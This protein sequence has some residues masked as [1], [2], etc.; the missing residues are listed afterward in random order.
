MVLVA[1]RK[2]VIAEQSVESV[3][4]VIAEQSVESVESVKSDLSGRLR[5]L[6]NDLQGGGV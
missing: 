1:D 2:S 5:E 4:S 6:R 3:E